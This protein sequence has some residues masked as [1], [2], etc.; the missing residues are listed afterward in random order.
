M[1]HTLESVVVFRVETKFSEK[2]ILVSKC[3]V[4]GE[5]KEGIAK[6]TFVVILT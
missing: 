6:E 1:F 4:F 3:E 5:K 2:C